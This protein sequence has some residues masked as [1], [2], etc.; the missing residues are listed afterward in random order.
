M[1]MEI[2]TA[3]SDLAEKWRS[4]HTVQRVV[5]VMPGGLV[6][7]KDPLTEMLSE[8]RA[9]SMRA[10]AL[11]LNTELQYLIGQ[12]MWGDVDRPATFDDW[13]IATYEVEIAYRRQLAW[14]RAQ[15]PG[16]PLLRVPQ[17]VANTPFTTPEFTWKAAWHRGDM[18]QGF[19][20]SPP[21]PLSFGKEVIDASH[22]L[23]ELRCA[24]RASPSWQELAQTR[25][26]LTE[27]DHAQLRSESR[28]LRAALMPDRIDEFEPHLALKRHQYREEQME[29]AIARLSGGAAAYAKAF[30]D[31]ADTVDFAVDE[32][33]PQLVTFGLPEEVGAAPDLDFVGEDRVA[34]RPVVPIFW[35]GML[36]FVSDPLVEEVGQ[37][38]SV[39][40]NFSAGIE[41]NRAT[42]RLLP[43]AASSWG[44]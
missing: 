25:A 19:Q 34:F 3:L 6:P 29:N 5:S 43:G 38:T 15:L 42:L 40:I 18:G 36:V 35:T 12:P 26:S 7:S 28:A 21:P 20:L 39:N 37:V 31:A 24:L 17:L 30:E 11:R 9:R 2:W 27:A 16:Y 33:L 41:N 4:S 23:Q 14:I 32:V 44:L 1:T 13:F 22:E 8:F 10:H